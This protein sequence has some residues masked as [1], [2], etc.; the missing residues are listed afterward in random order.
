MGMRKID[1]SLPRRV[2][3]IA[4]PTASGKSRFALELAKKY[5]GVIINCDSMQVYDELK[6]ITAR[7]SHSDEI[8]IPHKLYGIISVTD[9]FSVGIWRNLA[10]SEIK[11][12]WEFGKLPIITGGTGL[13]IKALME[14]L[15]EVP[16]VSKRIREAAIQRRKRIGA[17]AFHDELSKF[18]PE[19]A[20]RLDITDTQRVIRAYEVFM[21]TNFP[22]SHWHKQEKK[23][24]LFPANYQTIIFEPP[25]DTLYAKCEDRLEFMLKNGA[26]N[27]VRVLKNMNLDPNCPAMKA[28]GVPEFLAYLDNKMSLDEALY[29]AKQATRRYAKRQTTWFRNQIIQ[30]YRLKA[31]YSKRLLPEIFSNIII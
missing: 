15:S 13:Y 21:A 19:S 16:I 31:Q 24:V 9:S 5:G 20:E 4:G 8:N 10:I 2:L 6:I 28:L 14:G 22:L 30:N 7:P 17:E 11:A 25:R 3:I 29:G 18:D 26:L 12:C 27:E 23:T 1:L